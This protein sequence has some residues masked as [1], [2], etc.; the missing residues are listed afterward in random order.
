[1]GWAIF[2][3]AL[4]S[5]LTVKISDVLVRNCVCMRS[6]GFYIQMGAVADLQNIAF[7]GDTIAHN[8]YNSLAQY[9]IGYNSPAEY[10]I[11]TKRFDIVNC[12]FVYGYPWKYYPGGSTE[13]LTR[14][15]VGDSDARNEVINNEFGWGGEYPGCPDGCGYDFDSA[16]SGVTFKDN[17]VHDSYGEPVLFM[18]GYVNKDLLFEDNV[19]RDNI[20]FSTRWDSYVTMNSDNTG[21][22]TFSGNK[23]YLRPGQRAFNSKPTCY[24]YVDNDENASGTFVE[25]PMVT[26][27]TYG[28]GWRT[29]KLSCAT[30]GAAIRYTTD[31]SLP[32]P[33]SKAYTGPI[34]IERSGALNV[35]AFK[36]GC[37]NSYV[38]C[39]VV[40]L[41][42]HEGANPC[43]CWKP[44]N[45]LEFVGTG[46]AVKINS[47][48]LGR[49]S[50]NFTIAFWACPNATRVST[51]KALYMYSPDEKTAGVEGESG[52]RYA[53]APVFRG[54]GPDA[55]HAG[56]GVSVGTNGISVFESSDNYMPHMLVDDRALTGWN[57]ITV[58]Y[59]YRQPTLYLNGVYE[60]A[61]RT[62]TKTVHPVFN[63]GGM[64][65][66][67]YAG[68]LRDVRIY[69]RA[70]TDAEI[71]QLASTE[72]PR[73]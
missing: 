68:K 39:I 16:T 35:K 64:E 73:Q 40:E 5:P 69:D 56:V 14:G 62:S 32:G 43:V 46:N 57:H 20:R 47:P 15:I 18:P 59:R 70:L 29:Y 66:N 23:F 13:V 65:N 48:G 6:Q 67:W 71:Q 41:R 31:G 34:K 1:M 21:N 22:G 72:L 44:D 52:Q 7:D 54:G 36:K 8:S 10:R 33:S 27:I 17:F 4:Q 26:H 53:I 58:V 12:A 60:T 63:L 25:M 49:I 50:D 55:G 45:S 9:Q 42:D 51:A 19:L 38:N 24:S 37:V 28:A 30:P 3:D 11:G 61:G 2:I